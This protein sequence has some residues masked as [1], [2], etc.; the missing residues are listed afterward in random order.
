MMQLW[1]LNHLVDMMGDG[2]LV[3]LYESNRALASEIINF[4]LYGILAR[5]E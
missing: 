5:K 3:A 4:F 2:R 1:F